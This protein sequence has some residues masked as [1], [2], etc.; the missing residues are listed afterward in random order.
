MSSLKTGV[1]TILQKQRFT[2]HSLFSP[3]IQFFSKII[4]PGFKVSTKPLKKVD[5]TTPLPLVIS[6]SKDLLLCEKYKGRTFQHYEILLIFF[7]KT[8]TLSCNHRT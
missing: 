3:L 6:K 4:L 7:K 1:L 2:N 8:N 5:V